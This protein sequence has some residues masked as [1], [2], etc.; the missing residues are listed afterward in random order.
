MFSDGR[1]YLIL[2]EIACLNIFQVC[3]AS[4]SGMSNLRLIIT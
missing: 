3:L 4:I 1:F 2:Y